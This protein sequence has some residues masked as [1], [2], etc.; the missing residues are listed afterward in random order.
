MDSTRLKMFALLIDGVM[1]G[2]GLR[3]DTTSYPRTQ[4]SISPTKRRL[5]TV[6][7]YKD[8]TSQ[9]RMRNRTVEWLEPCDPKG[10]RTVLRGR[11]HRKVPE[12]PRQ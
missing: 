5:S 2:I 4:N 3:T 6:E 11:G 9:S 1:K 10:S 12:L 8:A 7:W